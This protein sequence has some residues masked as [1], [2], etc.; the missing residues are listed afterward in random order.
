[1][2]DILRAD[3]YGFHALEIQPGFWERES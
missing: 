3:T 2:F 1:M